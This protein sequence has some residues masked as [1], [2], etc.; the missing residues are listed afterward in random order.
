MDDLTSCRSVAQIALWCIIR[1]RSI[2]YRLSRKSSDPVLA[3][4]LFTSAIARIRTAENLLEFFRETGTTVE[5][6]RLQPQNPQR[7]LLRC[8]NDS[9][10][11]IIGL[12]L[13][14]DHSWID[15]NNFLDLAAAAR[16][17]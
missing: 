6:I 4:E 1:L 12:D 8:L 11:G 13:Q 16:Y 2:F 10:L 5:A 17:P 9:T 14:L 3:A 15:S 7:Q